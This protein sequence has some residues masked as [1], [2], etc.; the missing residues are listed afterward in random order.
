MKLQITEEYR[1]NS[2]DELNYTLEK[3]IVT[4]KNTSWKI[5]GY[6]N[7]LEHLIEKLVNTKVREIYLHDVRRIHEAINDISEEI[8]YFVEKAID[9]IRGI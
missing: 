7:N 5:I 9:K 6:Y 1:I 8:K 2:A 4:E 3:K